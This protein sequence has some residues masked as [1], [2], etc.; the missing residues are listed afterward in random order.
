M[1]Q[2]PQKSGADT[3]AHPVPTHDFSLPFT[4]AVAVDFIVSKI[5]KRSFD[6]I[7]L[8]S[9]ERKLPTFAVRNCTG[10]VRDVA[11]LS[12]ADHD[13][14]EAEGGDSGSGHDWAVSYEPVIPHLHRSRL[15]R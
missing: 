4:S 14:G 7:F 8:Q 3:I 6:K 10:F 13:A 1:Q 11:D 15:P 2:Q 5:L 12:L 9:V